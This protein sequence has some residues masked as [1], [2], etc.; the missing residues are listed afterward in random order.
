MSLL[1]KKRGLQGSNCKLIYKFVRCNNSKE[2]RVQCVD[3]LTLSK[4]KTTSTLMLITKLR[5]KSKLSSPIPSIESILDTREGRELLHLVILQRKFVK[6]TQ[7]FL[8]AFISLYCN[9][10]TIF[11]SFEIIRFLQDAMEVQRLISF[12][13]F[14]H[15]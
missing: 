2:I 1:I 13:K 8:Y 3:K 14:I 10:G 12:E 5:K 11:K 6:K 4:E 9:K 7:F 15:L